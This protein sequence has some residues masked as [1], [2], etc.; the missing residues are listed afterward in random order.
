MITDLMDRGASAL[1]TEFDRGFAEAP[2]APV[3]TVAILSVRA[4]A[5]TLALRRAQLARVHVALPLVRLPTRARGLLG[6]VAVRGR[7]LPAWDLGM[8]AGRGAATRPRWFAIAAG[9]PLALAFDELLAHLHVPIDQL[10]RYPMFDLD[11]VFRRA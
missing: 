11:E 6:V 4:G 9:E 7:V 10:S 5:T 1:R 8:L 3:E 2:A